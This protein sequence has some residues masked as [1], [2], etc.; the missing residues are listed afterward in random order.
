MRGR[1]GIGIFFRWFTVIATLLAVAGFGWLAFTSDIAVLNPAGEVASRQRDLLIFAFLLSMVVV[2]PVFALTIF[3]AIR[4]REGNEKAA[5]R[6]EWSHSRVL[7]TIWW[8]VPALIIVVLGVVTWRTSHTLDP[9]RPLVSNTRPVEIQVIALEWKW[10][11]LYPEYDVAS[12]NLLPV[13]TDK[14]L[15]FSITSDAPMN[16]FWIPK[17]GSQIYAMKGMQTKLHLSADTPGNYR[18]LSTNISG[19]GFAD[20]DFEV[21]AMSDRDFSN[22][23]RTTKGI[24][25]YLDAP[26]YDKLAKPGTLDEPI[27]F[28]GFSPTLFNDTITS[29]MSP[30][31]GS[32]TTDHKKEGRH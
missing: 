21:Q 30:S 27:L 23:V 31:S 28:S 9:Y 18:G 22:W 24:S 8:G 15:N 10:L 1:R 25:S 5:Y 2:I 16:S 32:S 11:F 6:P 14:P 7:E 17:L 19:E 26:A 12:V 3:I 20:M 29:W 4:Y 13:P